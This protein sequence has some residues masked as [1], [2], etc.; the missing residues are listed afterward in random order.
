MI[1]IVPL[2]DY[3]QYLQQVVDWQ[4]RAFGNENSRAFFASVVESGLRGADL[5]IT[6]IALRGET[7]VGTVGLWRCDL[8]SRQDLT[9]WLAALYVDESQR[10]S[11]LG[12]RLQQHVQDYS[13]RAGFSELYLYSD[14]SGYYERHGWHYIGDALDYPDRPVRLYHRALV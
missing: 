12:L 14:F 6:F 4:W 3:P 2:A 5:P 9:P 8:I 13:R 11:G 7:L 1:N 10:G